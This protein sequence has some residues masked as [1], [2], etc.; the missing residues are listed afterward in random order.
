MS[1]RH[2]LLGLLAERPRTGYALLKHFEES[3]DYVWSARHSQI[4][5]ELARLREQG[6]I[7]QSA[8]GPRG[9]K[10][11]EIT[12][13]G[14][15]E[16]RRWLRD[17]SPERTARSDPLLRVFL[18]WLLEPDERQAFLRR[19]LEHNRTYLGELEQLGEGE[20][21]NATEQSFRFALEHGLRATRA[22]I[23]WLEWA[24]AQPPLPDD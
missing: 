21:A 3:I 22:R 18:L 6:L 1:L 10:T 14:R 5:P 13:A 2:A 23:Q 17:T 16:V 19:E 4:Y 9:S 7:R 8:S 24:L 20:P 11:Y 15:K 12:A